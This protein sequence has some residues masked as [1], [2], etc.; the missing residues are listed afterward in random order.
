MPYNETKGILSLHRRTQKDWNVL[1]HGTCNYGIDSLLSLPKIRLCSFSLNPPGFSFLK[2]DN[3]AFLQSGSVIQSLPFLIWNK[4]LASD[5]SRPLWSWGKICTN[6]Y[7]VVPLHKTAT[8]KLAIQASFLTEVF[9]WLRISTIFPGT[10][11][12]CTCSE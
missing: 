7:H 8:K 1:C 11:H 10:T 12:Q 9:R 6:S 4:V 2:I 5:L 3:A